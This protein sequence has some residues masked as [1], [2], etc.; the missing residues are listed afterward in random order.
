MTSRRAVVVWA[1][2]RLKLCR[3]CGGRVDHWLVERGKYLHP[4]CNPKEKA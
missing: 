2:P 4:T 1:T 3:R